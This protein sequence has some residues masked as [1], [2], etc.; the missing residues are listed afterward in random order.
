MV[1]AGITD[2]QDAFMYGANTE[3]RDTFTWSV[4]GFSGQAEVQG[5][6]GQSTSG[7]SASGNVQGN[8][9]VRGLIN[10]DVSRGYFNSG[11]Q[12]DSFS[13]EQATLVHGPNS[14]MFGLGS[15]AGIFDYTPKKAKFR[16]VGELSFR[17]D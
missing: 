17:L 10:A 3:G 13:I 4:P 6:F 11:A 12:M 16:D 7:I 8:Q 5:P 15:P 14:I 2:V 1:D 9:R